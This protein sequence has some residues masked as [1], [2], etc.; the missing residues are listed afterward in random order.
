MHSAS[1][2]GGMLAV[3]LPE[4]KVHEVLGELFVPALTLAAIN[5]PSSTVISGPLSDLAYVEKSLREKK[6]R[7][8]MVTSEYAFHHS[9][10]NQAAQKLKAAIEETKILDGKCGSA[11]CAFISTS[12]LFCIHPGDVCERVAESSYWCAQMTNSVRFRD[13]VSNAL[14][15]GIDAAIEVGPNPVLLPRLAECADNL[16]TFSTLRRNG[17]DRNEILQCAGQ[18][19]AA[20]YAVDWHALYGLSLSRGQIS[21][22]PYAWDRVKCWVSTNISVR[23]CSDVVGNTDVAAS[24]FGNGT[25]GAS[26]VPMEP[27]DVTS[28]LRSLF[29]DFMD[30]AVSSIE[31]EKPLADYGLDS[32]SKARFRNVVNDVYGV[33]FP[34]H[35]PQELV[36]ISYLANFVNEQMAELQAAAPSEIVSV[37]AASAAARVSQQAGVIRKSGVRIEEDLSS[38]IAEWQERMKIIEKYGIENPFYRVQDRVSENTA[39]ING[40]RL[41]NFSCYN[42]LGLSGS[43][44]LNEAAKDAVDRFG[45]SVS[46]SRILSGEKT[47]HQELERELASFLGCEDSLV[48]LGGHS[49]NESAIGFIVDGDYDLIIAD[50]A[51]HNSIVKGMQ[52]S[53]CSYQMF[54]H[55][56]MEDLESK[57]ALHRGAY[58]RCLIIVEG[59]YSMDADFCNLFQLVRLKKKY[60]AM[61]YV[62]E[63]HSV[64]VLGETG[65]GIGELYPVDR[66]DVDLW[67]GTL[68]KSLGSCGG[69]L[70]G[71]GDLIQYLKY[72]VPGFIFSAGITPANTAAALAA[73]LELKRSNHRVR[74][75]QFNAQRFANRA[76]EHNLD[77]R[78]RFPSGI[79]M[80]MLYDTEK[81]IAVSAGMYLRGI[82]VL[83]AVHPAVPEG[84]A[85][86]RF[87]ISAM[88]TEEQI[89]SAVDNLAEVVQMVFAASVEQI[90]ASVNASTNKRTSV[91][92]EPG[93]RRKG[94][95]VKRGHMRKNWLMRWF[96]LSADYL[97]YGDSAN[98]RPKRSIPLQAIKS[99]TML[100]DAVLGQQNCFMVNGGDF[101]LYCYADSKRNAQEWVTA[102][103]KAKRDLSL[104][105]E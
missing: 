24:S 51:V 43:A 83:P 66:G 52:L 102:I 4:E 21:L 48:M 61:L 101:V 67:M 32:L 42:Y 96:T 9:S 75:L 80:V 88:H 79:V 82:S 3:E 6:I 45:T 22:P 99:V 98:A 10:L 86:L 105:S 103:I 30:L 47:I 1:G 62:D 39:V 37:S 57:L 87:F 46:G 28:T 91:M 41:V 33:K 56:D 64:G 85:R 34:L 72:N 55:N 71:K 53:R 73:V 13:A 92:L 63:A 35:V 19:W 65:R 20:G 49:C 2:N 25:E 7:V 100:D 93:V 70:A 76:K 81:T 90:R 26:S 12:E 54:M 69:Y 23:G 50:E 27:A 60:K 97:F 78:F 17:N 89:D 95:L 77:V 8:K 94:W 68:S 18:V 29:A 44:A 31:N 11:S 16:R 59:L 15:L 5:S 38:D 74:A 40:R 104:A 84:Q 14:D 36:T 58:R